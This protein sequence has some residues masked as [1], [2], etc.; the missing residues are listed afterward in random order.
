MMRE[1]R[2]KREGAAGAWRGIALEELAG[3]RE[4]ALG[5]LS[6]SGAWEML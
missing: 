5:T 4:I 1:M 3:E 6:G 2:G